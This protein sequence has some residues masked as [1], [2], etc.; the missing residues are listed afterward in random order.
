MKVTAGQTAVITGAGSGI[1]RALAIAC[2]QRGLNVVAADLDEQRLD[3]LAAELASSDGEVLCQPVDVAGR[4]SIES[5]AELAYQR[6]GRV[7]LLF[8][9]AGML[10]SGLCWETSLAEWQRVIDVNL[11]SVLHGIQVFVPRMLAQGTAAHI[12]NTASMAGLLS[13]PRMGAYSVSKHAVVA[14]SQT[15]HYELQE[16]GAEIG[17]SVACPAQI[18]SNI[19]QGVADT[20][21]TT[22]QLN[23][24]L[25]T[26]V[27]AGM[28]AEQL[29]ALMLAAVDEQ[30]FWVFSHDDFKAEYRRRAEELLADQN[31][32]FQMAICE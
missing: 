24:F 26:G 17:V 20:D 5:L 19:M 6:F 25:R 3:A 11:M 15:L 18:Q 8:N 16:Q 29:A 13:S 31:P 4:E 1:G 28:P 14:L 32:Q 2:A 12:V 10:R 30:R 21:E 27:A 23:E 7:E 22:G 9:N